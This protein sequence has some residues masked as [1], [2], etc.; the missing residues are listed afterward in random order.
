MYHSRA[1]RWKAGW[2]PPARPT[3]IRR[4]SRRAEALTCSKRESALGHTRSYL[5]DT[6][7]ADIRANIHVAIIHQAAKPPLLQC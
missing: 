1:K 4:I 6:V 7:H 3:C 5:Y 2:L